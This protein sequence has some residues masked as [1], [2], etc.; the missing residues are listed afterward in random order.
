MGTDERSEQA[1]GEGGVESGGGPFK[2]V[3]KPR[4]TA[5]TRKRD[6]KGRREYTGE[7]RLL[8]LDTWNR[9]QLPGTEF[10]HLVGVTP[11]TL[12]TWKRRFEAEGPAGLMGYRRG[13]RG[14]RLPEHVR[15]S[16]LMMKDQHPDWGQDRIH[17]ML[18][19]T[20]SLQASAGAVQRVL[21]EAGYEVEPAVTKPNPPKP[22]RFERTRATPVALRRTH[23]PHRVL[24]RALA[25]R[26]SRRVRPYAAGG[27]RASKRPRTCLRARW[28]RMRSTTTGSVTTATI[29][30]SSPQRGHTSASTS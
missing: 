14:S 5:S 6:T 19:R 23:R 17:D 15:R 13:Q 30:S 11:Q 3:G 22:Q 7:E 25:R 9:S 27:A 16:I 29:T 8:L 26:S 18:L 24:V 2:P 28:A 1:P 21:I 4:R 12:A 10:S 20:Q